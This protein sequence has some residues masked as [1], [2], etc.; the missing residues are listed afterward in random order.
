MIATKTYAFVKLDAKPSK[1]LNNIFL[2]T[3][4]NTIG[5]GILNPLDKVAMMLT[6]KQIIKQRR[7]HTANV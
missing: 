1:R 7:T 2:C 6:G 3:R 5:V 4:N